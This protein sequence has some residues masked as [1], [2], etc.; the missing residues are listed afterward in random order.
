MRVGHRFGL[1]QQARAL[2]IGGKHRLE[3]GQAARRGF[4]R[5]IAQTAAARHVDR[6]A[7]GIDLADQRFHQRRFAG[8][9]SASIG[10]SDFGDAALD[11][12]AARAVAMAKVV[13][14]DP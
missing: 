13:P 1:G 7:I 14:E 4:L 2:G 8:T 6:S 10:S 11:E 5:D 3:R 12:L 9:G